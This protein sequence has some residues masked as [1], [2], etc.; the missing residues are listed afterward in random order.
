MRTGKPK[1][2]IH[3]PEELCKRLLYDPE[4]G[5]LTWRPVPELD[6][7]SRRWN[8]RW[9]GKLAGSPTP[10]G[11]IR[12]CVDYRVYLAH[13]VAWAVHYGE[14]PEL[15]I[16]HINRD[17]M[18]N[19]IANLRH[20]TH[21]QNMANASVRTDNTSGYRGVSKDY[22]TNQWLAQIWV[23]GKHHRVGLFQT[24]DEAFDAYCKAGK[25]LRGEYFRP[26]TTNG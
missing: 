21:S 12:I 9:S 26:A 24:K 17:G 18:D 15:F 14:W 8:M 22:Y 4:T 13:R 20:V 5:M 7:H 2:P 23:D 25:V 10:T 1:P 3:T 11:Y 16:D 19:R 6:R